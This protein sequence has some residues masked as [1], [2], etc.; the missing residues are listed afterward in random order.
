MI[1][2]QEIAISI[3]F[4]I[5]LYYYGFWDNI[6]S[7]YTDNIQKDISQP[8]NIHITLISIVYLL[9][10]ILIIYFAI[11][12]DRYLLMVIFGI[13]LFILKYSSKKSD[14]N[15]GLSVIATMIGWLIFII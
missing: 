8:F 1:N 6:A 14:M 5:L 15:K 11:I 3:C 9:N 2:P 12:F 10:V 13:C 7:Q 4:I